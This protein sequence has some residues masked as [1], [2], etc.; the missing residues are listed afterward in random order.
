MLDAVGVLGEAKHQL[1]VLDA[2]VARVEA[3]DALDERP[4]HDEQ[5]ADVHDAAEE[6]GRPVRLEERLRAGR[7]RR[8]ILSSSV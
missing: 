5:V 3:A 6:L 4:P 7:P 2:V 8:S 1:E